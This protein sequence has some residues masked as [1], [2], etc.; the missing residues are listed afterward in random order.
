MLDPPLRTRLQGWIAERLGDPDAAIEA[1]KPLS[2]GAIQENWRIVCRLGDGSQRE[3]ALRKDALATIASSRARDEEFALLKAA[4]DAGVLVPEPIGFCDDEGVIGARFALMA[5]VPG[6]GL[7]PRVVK[8]HALGGDRHALAERLGR[9]LA[10][11]H[12]IRPPRPDLAFLGE[13]SP[14]PARAEVAAMRTALDRLGVARPTLE[15]GLRWAELSAPASP[16]PT[17]VHRDFRTG[18]YM[19]D[20]RGLTAVLD[21]EFA[22]WGDPMSDIGWFCAECWRFGR[23]DLEAGGIAPR[24]DFYRGYEAESGVAIDGEIVRYWE[25]MAHLRWAVIALEQAHRHLSGAEF[26]LELALTG[27]VVPELESAVLRETA[28]DRWRTADA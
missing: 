3:F 12:T 27:R 26:S 1:P 7:G 18:N 14:D 19:V 28:P 21:W 10:K 9:E 13:P 23:P 15:W 24:A 16:R 25:I 8:D 20:E 2:G 11:I 5:L 22:G 4:H 6:V 17:L